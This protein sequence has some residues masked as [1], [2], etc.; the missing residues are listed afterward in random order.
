M[1][2]SVNEDERACSVGS[3]D[4]RNDDIIS[5][6]VSEQSV[7]CVDVIELRARTKGMVWERETFFGGAAT[8]K[9]RLRTPFTIAIPFAEHKN[10]AR[11]ETVNHEW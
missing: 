11:K 8:Q 6:L 4:C 5:K 7:V 3:G 2:S 10:F 1:F 9:L